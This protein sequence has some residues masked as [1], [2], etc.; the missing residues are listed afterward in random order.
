M[1][2]GVRYITGQAFEMESITKAAQAQGCS[3]GFDLAH[4]IGNIPLALHD[5]NVDFAVWC[6]YKYLNSGPGG[7]A[8]CFVHERHAENTNLPRFA[9]WWGH[10]KA[11]RFLMRPEFKAIAGAEG[12]QLSN[13][14]IL[15]LASLRASLELFDAA[16]MPAL[17]KKSE[18]LTGYFEF[19]LQS[20]L[21]EKI[22]LITPT[23]S[24]QR[25]CQLSLLIK[26]R[27]RDQARAIYES[28][29][30]NDCICDWREPAVIRATPIPL[31][32]TFSDV[33]RFVELLRIAY[34]ENESK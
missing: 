6:S 18:L 31:Y 4:A 10:D 22:A 7:I 5:W 33:H 9:G 34:E 1:L 24:R 29:L 14:P 30:K 8:G 15:Q 25:G 3:V 11:T 17:R 16:G 21:P 12:W 28:L 27:S 20:T 26:N 19:L 2:G 13:P 23:D 32:N